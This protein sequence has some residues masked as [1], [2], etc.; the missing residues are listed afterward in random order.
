MISFLF[1]REITKWVNSSLFSWWWWF[2]PP[3]TTFP[4][5]LFQDLTPSYDEGE[6]K[7][8]L[9]VFSMKGQTDRKKIWN[10]KTHDS[11]KDKDHHQKRRRGRFIC[12]LSLFVVH[13][14]GSCTTNFSLVFSLQF[15]P[16]CNDPSLFCFSSA[17][18]SLVEN[19]ITT[20]LLFY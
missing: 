8:S 3:S 12:I 6:K 15:R 16:P 9:V 4:L 19:T 10:R 2:K 7:F 13:L 1:Y 5:N 14:Q 20:L 17:C 11:S 18:P